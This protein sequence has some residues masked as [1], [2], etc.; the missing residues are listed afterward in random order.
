MRRIQQVLA[1]AVLC[2]PALS[3]R[4][5]DAYQISKTDAVV[6]VGSKG[7][8]SVTIAAKKGW[9]LN[10]EAPLTLKLGSTPGVE[11]EKAKLVRSDLA[12]S[13]EKEA[14]FDVAVTASEPGKKSLDAE[15]GFVLCQESECRPVKEK[16]SI[17][18]EASDGKAET[19]A[20]TK[21]SGKTSKTKAKK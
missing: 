7:K 20:A 2:A 4:A 19:A 13:N 17:A 6:T 16:L 10:A 5:D 11:P 3:A 9:H 12:M 15:A 18:V 21:P 14:R 8:A 1:F